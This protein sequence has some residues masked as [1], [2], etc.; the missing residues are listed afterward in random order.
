MAHGAKSL[1]M[2]TMMQQVDFY[3]HELDYMG[4]RDPELM[5]FLYELHQ[6]GNKSQN[7]G[8]NQQCIIMA[9]ICADKRDGYFECIG[10]VSKEFPENSHVEVLNRCT[11]REKRLAKCVKDNLFEAL[12]YRY[13]T[14]LSGL[15]GKGSP[16]L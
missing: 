13:E 7:M 15:P 12:D 3:Q 8:E 4:A 10:K 6:C 9:D 14:D 1:G 11:I 2:C 5:K 16:Q